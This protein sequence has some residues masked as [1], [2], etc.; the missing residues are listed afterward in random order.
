MD[1][2]EVWLLGSSVA[3]LGNS[4]STIIKLENGNE[5]SNVLLDYMKS[6]PGKLSLKKWVEKSDSDREQ[7]KCIGMIGKLVAWAKR[8]FGVANTCV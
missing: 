5:V 4:L 7:R 2:R 3:T 1:E 8:F 6:I